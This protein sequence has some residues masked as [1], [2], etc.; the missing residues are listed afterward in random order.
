MRYLRTWFATDCAGKRVEGGVVG[1]G[2]RGIRTKSR[3][4]MNW[5]MPLSRGETGENLKHIGSL[6][7]GVIQGYGLRC[8]RACL[9]AQRPCAN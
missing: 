7:S 2:C 6:D 4:G 1:G 8:C 3:N 9:F 5:P